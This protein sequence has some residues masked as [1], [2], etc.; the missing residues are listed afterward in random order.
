MLPVAFPVSRLR[1]LVP[2]VVGV[3]VIALASGY[4]ASNYIRR[5]DARWDRSVAG[6]AVNFRLGLGMKLL[7]TW[8]DSP[9][10]AI[11]F[12]LGNSASYD[13]N[14]L[15]SYP[16]DIAL[17]TLGEEGLIGAVLYLQV[18]WLAGRGLLKCLRLARDRP[19]IRGVLAASSANFMF[20]LI[21]SLKEGSM[22]SSSFY[23]LAAI[24]LARMPELALASEDL[25]PKTAARPGS[26]PAR[27]L[28]ANLMR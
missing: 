27:P 3:M 10:F 19:E 22:L 20:S 12:G 28:F 5:D 21:I 18:L 7:S 11:L 17:E 2:I 8:S 4:A 15:G 13:P 16:H 9:P 26:A 23:F 14:L 6:S 24:V 1:G 25:Q